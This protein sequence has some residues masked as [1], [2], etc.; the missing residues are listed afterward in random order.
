MAY[1]KGKNGDKGALNIGMMVEIQ[2]RSPVA[3]EKHGAG[4]Q[5]PIAVTFKKTINNGVKA[6]KQ[7]VVNHDQRLT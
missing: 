5:F 6:G 3:Q 4:K 7:S 1:N 2:P